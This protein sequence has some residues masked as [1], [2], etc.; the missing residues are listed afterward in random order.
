LLLNLGMSGLDRLISHPRRLELDRVDLA[1]TQERAWEAVRHGRLP[2]SRLTKLLFAIRTLPERL[3]GKTVD[4]AGLRLDDMRSSEDRPGFQVLVDDP[5]HEVV[6]GAIGRVWQLEIPF[7][8]VPDAAAFAAFEEPGWIKVAWALRVV[9]RG[10][11]AS[12]LELELRVDATDDESWAKFKRY[13][14]LIG[15]AS[16]LIR[17]S[18]LAALARDPGAL[19][20]DDLLPDATDQVTQDLTIAATPEQIWPW[21]VQM[22][23]GRAGFYSLDLLDNGGRPSAREIHPELQHIEVGQILPA[24]PHGPDGFEV[25]RIDPQRALVLGGLFDAAASRQLPFKS[26]RPKRYWHVTWAFALE[27]LDPHMTRLRVRARAAY[28]PSGRLH[29]TWI[30]PVHAMMQF[31]QLRNI[32]ARA[33]GRL[34]RDTWRDV[35]DG[36]RGVGRIVLDFLTPRRPRSLWGIEDA[37]SASYPGDEIV[38][39]P[40]WGWTHAVEIDAPAAAVWPWVA[41]IGADRGGF[42]SYQWLENLAGCNVRNAEIVHPDWQL[43]L[44]DELLLHPKVPPLRVVELNPGRHFVASVGPGPDDPTPATSWVA[45]TWLFQVEPLSDRRCRFVSRYRVATSDDLR[46]RAGF[47]EFLIEPIGFAMDR[48]ML[49]GV[50]DRVERERSRAE[51]AWRDHRG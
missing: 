20:G 18:L 12:R 23:C 41:Q 8:H 13:F 29:A 10:E 46:T 31:V 28:P 38:T 9:R 48:R 47:G 3:A 6:V 37:A 4:E 5:P 32:A 42:Y 30:R 1:V 51:T 17:R 21:L 50:K 35:V 7:L 34:R 44:G 24:T 33:E 45:A 43:G 40:R 26:T 22:G 14:L 39:H 2:Q 11:R 49:L 15:P 19:P 27:P 36:I 25:L 16:R